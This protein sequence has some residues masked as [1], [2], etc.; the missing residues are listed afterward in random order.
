MKT[1]NAIIEELIQ[2]RIDALKR[3]DAKGFLSYYKKGFDTYELGPPLEYLDGDPS[4]TSGLDQW[5]S[6][7][8]GPIE[9]GI[10]DYRSFAGDN[11]AFCYF[12]YYM[13]GKKADGTDIKMWAR[14]TLGLV[15]MD[16]EWK[17][18]HSH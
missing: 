12:L 17:V 10:K 6:S 15:K 13:A 5:F 3:K 9:Y 2:Q 1:D 14:Q 11:T 18:Q 4:N 16:G 8:K 7:F